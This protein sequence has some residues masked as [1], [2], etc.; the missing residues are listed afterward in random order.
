MARRKDEEALRQLVDE[1]LVKAMQRRAITGFY[2]QRLEYNTNGGL[3]DAWFVDC[4]TDFAATIGY[5]RDDVIGKASRSMTYPGWWEGIAASYDRSRLMGAN[6]ISTIY[7]SWLSREGVEIKTRILGGTLLD[8]HDLMFATC[9]VERVGEYPFDLVVPG[10]PRNTNV[11]TLT[12]K[13]PTE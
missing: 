8:D 4:S 5:H 13:K 12:F 7:K 10:I 9:W 3:I 1:V 11:V 2:L 6:P